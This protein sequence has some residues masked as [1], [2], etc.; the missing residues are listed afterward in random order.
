M[1]TDRTIVANPTPIRSL[2][3]RA[4]TLHSDFLRDGHSRI[5]Q[6]PANSRT[7]PA[8]SNEG[9]DVRHSRR[10]IAVETLQSL[11][12]QDRVISDCDETTDAMGT[13]NEPFRKL[14]SGQRRVDRRLAALGND[15]VQEAS[16]F[17][18][19]IDL[20][21]TNAHSTSLLSK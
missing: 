15:V 11:E 17:F 21:V 7:S 14:P 10:Q 8:F 5:R 1:E 3:H 20:S 13:N 4:N 12:T 9:S 16:E 2:D 19:I 18:C 6:A